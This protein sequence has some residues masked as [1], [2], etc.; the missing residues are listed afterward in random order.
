MKN[1]AKT[2]KRYIEAA[3]SVLIERGFERT[4]LEA[5]ARK[6]QTSASSLLRHFESKDD[7]IF[8]LLDQELTQIFEKHLN[9]ILLRIGSFF[10]PTRTVLEIIETIYILTEKD[11]DLAVVFF[12]GRRFFELHFEE[13][14]QIIELLKGIDK[15]IGNAQRRGKLRKDIHPQALR[16]LL[17]GAVVGVFRDQRM[18]KEH[19]DYP[20]N[21]SS[22]DIKQ[23]LKALLMGIEQG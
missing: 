20:A 11:G 18:A 9:P 21:F 15:A 14:P 12:E 19:K 3:K 2:R 4:T 8:A 1:P 13:F 6:A 23:T 17:L 5:I 22:E 16:S 10:D 7:L